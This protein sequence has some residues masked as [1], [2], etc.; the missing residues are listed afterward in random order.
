MVFFVFL[1][2][3]LIHNIQRIATLGVYRF[4]QADRTLDRIQGIYDHFFFNADLIS[5]FIDRWFLQILFDH[6][7]FG[8][9]GF[10]GNVAQRTA[11]PDTVIIP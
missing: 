3:D 7:F 11:Y 4:K 10:I 5:N 6:I 1:I 8:I 2:A 9:N